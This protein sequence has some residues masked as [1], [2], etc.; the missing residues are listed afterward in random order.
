MKELVCI[1]CPRGCLLRVDDDLNVT[2]AF[3]PRGKQYAIREIT[4]PVRDI[5]SSIRVNNR[6][7]TLASVKT[8][9]PVPKDKIFDV[10]DEIAKLSVDAPTTIGQVVKQNV[11]G[12]SID[13]IVTKK[14]D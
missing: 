2:G 5:A 13:I 4:N 14:I 1:V 6:P 12:L 3:C 7:F 11:L 10:M 9:K 8:S